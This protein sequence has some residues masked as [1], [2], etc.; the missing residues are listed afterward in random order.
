MPAGLLRR[1]CLAASSH[2]PSSAKVAALRGQ[3]TFWGVG[4]KLDEALKIHL[5]EG[6]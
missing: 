1:A 4:W 2:A 5:K 6:I 3:N